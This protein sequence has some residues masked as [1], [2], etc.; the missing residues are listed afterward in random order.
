MVA[1]YLEGCK[2]FR[3]LFFRSL[4]ETFENPCF[5]RDSYGIF[6]CSQKQSKLVWWGCVRRNPIPH[7][8]SSKSETSNIPFV[9]GLVGHFARNPRRPGFVGLW[10]Q[11]PSGIP[12]LDQ[13]HHQRH[14]RHHV[15]ILLRGRHAWS[16]VLLALPCPLHPTRYQD[17]LDWTLGPGSGKPGD[18][19]NNAQTDSFKKRSSFLEPSFQQLTNLSPFFKYSFLG[20]L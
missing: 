9:F 17:L 15:R 11:S 3:K 20:R 7:F 5:N 16:E 13:R 14:L 6:R 10:G 12:D 1:R 19:L 4:S 8:Q 18:C 2:I